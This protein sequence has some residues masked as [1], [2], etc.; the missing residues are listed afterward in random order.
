[1]GASETTIAFLVEIDLSSLKPTT[2]YKLCLFKKFRAGFQIPHS[3]EQVIKAPGVVV[4][5]TLE[6]TVLLLFRRRTD[7]YG[8]GKELWYQC[9]KKILIYRV[10]PI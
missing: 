10:H 1:M 5:L 7:R 6:V 9:A 2:A 4:L 8:Y 3:P